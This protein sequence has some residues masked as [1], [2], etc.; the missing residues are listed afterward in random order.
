MCFVGDAAAAQE[1]ETLFDRMRVGRLNAQSFAG[2]PP[3]SYGSMLQEGWRKPHLELLAL[4]RRA[5]PSPGPG[6]TGA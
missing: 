4:G 5:P 2:E 1:A 6:V 3:A